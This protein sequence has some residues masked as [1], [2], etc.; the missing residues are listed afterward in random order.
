MGGGGEQAWRTWEGHKKKEIEG[1]HRKISEEKLKGPKKFVGGMG[2][3]G[4]E[5]NKI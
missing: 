5:K 2:L 1:Q 4:G 3:V